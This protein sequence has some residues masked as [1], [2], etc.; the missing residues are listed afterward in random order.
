MHACRSIPC[1]TLIT[2]RAWLMLHAW[3]CP[4]PS[5]IVSVCIQTSLHVVTAEFWCI[6]CHSRSFFELLIFCVG[7]FNTCRSGGILYIVL[8]Y[9]CAE[10]SLS[11]TAQVSTWCTPTTRLMA[12]RHE[13][14]LTSSGASLPQ[15]DVRAECTNHPQRPRAALFRLDLYDEAPW[16]RCTLIYDVGGLLHP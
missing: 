8:Q 10:L 13:Q 5:S 9:V 6:C 11:L 2:E 14:T 16:L 1:L 4:T 15:V 7:S 12:S 3:P